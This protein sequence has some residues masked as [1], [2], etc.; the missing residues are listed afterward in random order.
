[1]IV[2]IPPKI[3]IRQNGLVIGQLSL[4]PAIKISMRR[5]ERYR[6]SQSCQTII[7]ADLNAQLGW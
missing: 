6:S 7:A 5:A 3:Y 1:M 4:F 2:T